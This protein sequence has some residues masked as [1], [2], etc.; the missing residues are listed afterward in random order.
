[1]TIVKPLEK[2]S[3]KKWALKQKYTTK[4][5]FMRTNMIQYEVSTMGDDSTFLE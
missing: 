1:M 2:L 3:R 4:I 5:N